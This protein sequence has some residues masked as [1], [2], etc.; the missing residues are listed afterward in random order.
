MS[1]YITKRLLMII[2]V[3]FTVVFLVFFMVRLIPGDTAE[4]IAGEQ[5]SAQEIENIRKQLKLDQPIHVQF[6]HYMSGLARGDLGRSARSKRPVMEELMAR[7]PNTVYLML[8]AIFIAVVVGVATGTISGV[9]PYSIFDTLSMFVALFGISMPVFWLG[10]MLIIYFSV[11][12][13]WLPSGGSGTWR[14]MILPAVA[15][16]TVPMA[17][18]S[19][20]TRSSVLDVMRQDYI[21]TARAKGLTEMSVVWRHALKNALIPVLTVIGLQMGTLLGGAVL[22]EKVFSWNGL[23]RLMVDSIV[24]RDYPVVQGAVL[25]IA[26]SFVFINLI[27]DILYGYLDSRIR[28]D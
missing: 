13:G 10:L 9:K 15:L 18:I 5:A 23:G 14:H 7:L 22:T 4:V 8:A 1:T 28:Y 16:A 25:L 24:A 17:T 21:R 11:N 26:T 6:G 3:L 2:P 27:V 12:L 20:M 19:R